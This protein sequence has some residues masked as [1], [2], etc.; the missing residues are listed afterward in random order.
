M[1]PNEDKKYLSS[2]HPPPQGERERGRSK[3]I[4]LFILYG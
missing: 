2:I 4:I 1:G 3:K